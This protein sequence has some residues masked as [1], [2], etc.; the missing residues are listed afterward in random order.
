MDAP[1]KFIALMG[2]IHCRTETGR[3]ARAISGEIPKEILQSTSPQSSIKVGQGSHPTVEVS[4]SAYMFDGRV[5]DFSASGLGIMRM[6]KQLSIGVRGICY[7]STPTHSYVVFD[8]QTAEEM[9]RNRIVR[10]DGET[11]VLIAGSDA[12]ELPYQGTS[13]PFPL[14]V[15]VPNNRLT[16]IRQAEGAGSPRE[17]ALTAMTGRPIAREKSSK[18]II[19]YV[20]RVPAEA[21]NYGTPNRP[22]SCPMSACLPKLAA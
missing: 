12:D 5:L 22:L 18:P 1:A 6:G 14:S 13:L 17:A 8:S 19:Y 9:R 11:I 21:A 3:T 7:A 4:F 10:P 2:D 15:V 16:V 20:P